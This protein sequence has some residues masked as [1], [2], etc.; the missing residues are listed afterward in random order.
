MDLMTRPRRPSIRKFHLKEAM[1]FQGKIERGR[2][3]V[4]KGGGHIEGDVA[5][6][7]QR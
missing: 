2:G 5:K 7:P 4:V 6:E 3:R 1:C